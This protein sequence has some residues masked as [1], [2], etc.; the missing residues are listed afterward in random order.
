MRKNNTFIYILTELNKLTCVKIR[1]V[2]NDFVL[3]YINRFKYNT[4]Y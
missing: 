4:N 2:N 3:N 1:L